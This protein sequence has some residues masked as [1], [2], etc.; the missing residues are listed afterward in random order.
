MANSIKQH[1]KSEEEQL[2][3]NTISHEI[4]QRTTL[5]ST[6]IQQ[7]SFQQTFA[8]TEFA[9]DQK[10]TSYPPQMDYMALEHN[11]SEM[12]NSVTA[13]KTVGTGCINTKQVHKNHQKQKKGF[14]AYITPGP[15]S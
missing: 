14:I 6:H 4:I 2:F 7:Q 3:S 1:R 15:K 13:G 10:D 12:E 9:F 11:S 5:S 8:Q